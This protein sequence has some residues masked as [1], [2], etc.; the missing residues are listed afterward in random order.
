MRIG[1]IAS[2]YLPIPPKKYGGT[3]RII[4]FLVKGLQ[5]LG[6]EVI[7]FAP[8]DSEVDCR[9]IPICEKSI[10]FGQTK[11]EDNS[12]QEIRDQVVKNTNDLIR[13]HISELDIIHSHGVDLIDFQDFPNLTT[14]HGPILLEHL[15]YFDARRQLFFISISKNQQETFPDLQYVGVAYNGLDPQPFI[16][17]PEPEDYLCFLGRMDREKNPHLA[18][19]L[20][21]QLE[22]KIK[23]AGKIDYGGSD[24][25]E[26]ECR[27]YL[28]NPLVEY[29]GELDMEEKIKLISKAKC[30]LHATGFRE[31]FGLSVLESA[32]CGTPTLAINRGSMPELIEEGRTGLLVE[33]F[34]E[35]YHKIQEAFAMDREYISQRARLLFNYKIMAK[36]YLLAY[37]KVIN[38]FHTGERHTD[39]RSNILSDIKH[40]LQA[41]WNNYSK[42]EK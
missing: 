4:Y 27:Q 30:N 18:I 15:D 19:Q 34:T 31:P 35:G 21:L 3:E 17:N 36:Q 42:L 39:N 6:H 29:L 10:P 24:Y 11:E 25:F 12:L 8:G 1:I 23:L 13:K 33:D 32:Y 40:Q 20:A 37:E 22:M 26:Q 5:E 28:D 14:L 7:L 38:L 2:P 9:L 16:F 41:L